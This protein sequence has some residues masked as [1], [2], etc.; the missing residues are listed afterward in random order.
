M[1]YSFPNSNPQS[2][3][4]WSNLFH[5]CK[6]I[7]TSEVFYQEVPFKQTLE[8][9]ITLNIGTSLKNGFRAKSE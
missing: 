6:V 5:Y 3:I 1:K 8:I 7:V 2:Q 9:M 4:S